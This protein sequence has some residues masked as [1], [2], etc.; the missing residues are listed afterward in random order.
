MRQLL[1]KAI[2]LLSGSLLPKDG[3]GSHIPNHCE[4]PQF[5]NR[6]LI[7]KTLLACIVSWAAFASV[8]QAGQDIAI[9]DQ[10]AMGDVPKAGPAKPGRLYDEQYR[11]QFHFS[12]KKNWTND[13][14]G[15]VFYK[16]E[17]H[18]FFQHNPNGLEWGSM[19]WGHAIS[20]DMLH[21]T[22]L[23]HA[24]YPDKL[25]TIFSGSAVIDWNNTAGFQ[26]GEEKPIVCI[27]TSAG[28]TSDESK[29]Q[30][31]T[32]SI[33]FSNDRGRTW[34]KYANNPVLKNISG[35]NRD[36][37]V[38]WHGA[39]KQWVMV[40]YLD[41]PKAKND[42]ALFGSP[43]LKDWKRLCTATLPGNTECPDFFELPVDGDAQKTKWVFW[44]ANNTYLLGT[45]D[46]KTFVAES[47]VQ[48]THWG[49][50]RY[51]AQTF[52][53]VPSSD[54]RRI[55]I[56]WMY[57]GKYP[58]MPFNQQ[59]SFPV[60]LSL[61]TFP[62][63]VRLCSSPVKEIDGLHGKQHAWSDLT[64]TPG[65][66]P[67][68]NVTD[69]LFDIRLDV[70]PGTATEIGLTVRGASLRYD[71]KQGRLTC[72]GSSAPVSLVQGRLSLQILVD[73]SSIEIFTAD[74]RVNMA[75][76]FL[77]PEEDRSLTLSCQGGN[78]RVRSL[79]VWK[80]KSIWPK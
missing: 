58:G 23:D 79:R 26:T 78:A 49:A 31:Y 60:A 30:P 67:L 52:S 18:L 71:V 42:Y 66:N 76:C 4:H 51:A 37:K 70:E 46:G 61:R 22:Q 50:N 3:R 55:Q 35:D 19:T 25:G 72:L 2:L 48:Q 69:E 39:S 63:G 20:P 40:L 43:N 62:E 5:F 64:L 24:L 77:P 36:P 41:D 8:A 57:G 1:I 74:G 28:G 7:M 13:P 65:D 29:G 68:V 38:L 44:G 17:Y 11:P 6:E 75:F 34:T 45:F 32:Q 14:N 16:G 73:R 59:M 54:G 53:D 47:G 33:A 21:W 9:A 56:A 27:Y 15:M 12:P 10:V 80:L